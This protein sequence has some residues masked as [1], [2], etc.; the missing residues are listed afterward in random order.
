V[1]ALNDDP[2][3]RRELDDDQFDVASYVDGNVVVLAP[4]GSGKTRVLV[5]AAAHR[6]R[7]SNE[8]VGYAHA[9]ALCLTFG[10]DAAREMHNRLRAAPLLVPPNRI[11]VRNYHGLC[12]LLLSRYGHV[13]GWPRNAALVP[14][15][16]NDSIID[17]AIA[18]LGVA[19]LT[20]RGVATAISALKGHR[21]GSDATVA[22]NVIAI[23]ERYDA[24]LAERFL[25]DYD[26]LILHTCA[27]LEQ[28]PRIRQIVHDAYPFLFVD[29]L[30]DTNLL[31]LDLL[32]QL[33]GPA[34]RVFAVADDDQMIYGWRDAHPGN[35]AEF[36]ERFEA[37]ERVLTGNYRCPPKIV[38]AANAVIIHNLRRRDDFMESRVEDRTGEVVVIA[39]HGLSDAEIVTQ[40]V[41]RALNDG[42][43]LGDIAVL[44]P[45]KFKF[46]EILDAF[47]RY[48]IRWVH[49]GGDKLADAQTVKLIRLSLR[50]V[51]GGAVAP[52]DAEQLQIQ[53]D[54]ES[55]ASAVLDVAAEASSASPRGLLGRL[56]AGFQLGTL[57]EPVRDP[58]AVRVLATM[59]RKAVDD[60]RPTTCSDLAA[61]L[62]LNWDRLEAAALRAEQA[63][64]VM[65]SF[66][67][68]GTEY[69]VVILP[70]M[71][72]GLVP[73]APKT[74]NV[75]WEESRRVFY[76]ALTRA[77]HRVVITYDGDREPSELV[78]YVLPHAT[79][80]DMR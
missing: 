49:P 63:V 64:K 10:T 75:D 12:M 4:P 59:F 7:H 15:P 35:I 62:L 61:T 58:D 8:L 32:G 45:H 53:A 56:L 5:N 52:A 22:A 6:I 26:D 71:N 48:G 30:Q 23:R 40:E 51:A 73:Y 57:R 74:R 24:I 39:G 3:L 11:L 66:T 68:K 19:G 38:D 55:V 2:L 21:P 67:A 36:L 29:E 65:T 1:T 33:I 44:A 46:D 79:H 42:Y 20:A 78:G 17:E 70:F 72:A 60:E 16:Q 9:R 25:R 50:A 43:A 34:T 80:T 13:I 69:P 18:D 31:Q 14:S 37:T 54:D 41:Q 76:V 77:E 27:L 28:N 47:D